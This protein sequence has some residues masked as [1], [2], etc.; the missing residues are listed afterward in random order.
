LPKPQTLQTGFTPT[1]FLSLSLF[2]FARLADSLSANECVEEFY[3]KGQDCFFLI[4]SF[5]VKTFY[6]RDSWKRLKW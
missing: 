4:V 5:D 2:G 1:P 3:E 6:I